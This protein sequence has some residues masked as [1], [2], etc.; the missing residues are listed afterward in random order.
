MSAGAPYVPAVAA[1]QH[2]Y[3]L[4]S[5]QSHGAKKPHFTCISAVRAFV[6]PHPPPAPAH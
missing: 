4:L 5:G 3:L 6:P 1:Q 2:F